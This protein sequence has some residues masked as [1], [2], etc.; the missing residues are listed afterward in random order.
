MKFY[1]V[2]CVGT[3]TQADPYRPDVPPGTPFACTDGQVNGG[4][5]GKMLV[6]VPD[7]AAAP[8]G[9]VAVKKYDELSA[10]DKAKV[11][12]Y[13]TE[14]AKTPKNTTKLATDFAALPATSLEKK[15][16]DYKLSGE[17]ETAS[18]FAG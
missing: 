3:G 8:A 17:D 10:A 15:A 2:N 9:G 16:V 11:D 6:G 4:L 5:A 18:W 13:K 7:G 12:T 14:K 1:E